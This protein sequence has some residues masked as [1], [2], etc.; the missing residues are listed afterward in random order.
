MTTDL[1]H[2]KS[3]IDQGKIVDA[4]SILTPL[5]YS[6]PHDIPAWFLYVETLDSTVKRLRVLEICL[7][8]NRG[9]PEV[10]EAVDV[11]HKRLNKLS[12]AKFVKAV[13]AVDGWKVPFFDLDAIE[14]SK[15][16]LPDIHLPV[17]E[18]VLSHLKNSSPHREA[19][20]HFD[21]ALLNNTQ[22]P[23]I[24]D[25][26][27]YFL[28]QAEKLPQ[29]CEYIIYGCPAVVHPES[30]IIFGFQKGPEIFYR[31]P[32][33]TVE[34]I[35]KHYEVVFDEAAGIKPGS[36]D[37]NSEFRTFDKYWINHGS[38]LTPSLIQKCYDFNG[39]VH[40]KSI[41][42]NIKEDLQ[43]L[44]PTRSEKLMNRLLNLSI[45]VLAIV[46]VAILYYIYKLIR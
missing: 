40:N 41:D 44:F 10:T 25:S 7:R 18:D 3:L 36:S 33:A 38:Y 24:S 20:V 32:P 1:E 8:Q 12:H 26:I 4:Q 31:L 11:L 13:T 2:A 17:N 15:G 5:I 34:T 29:P 35:S 42:L 16:R 21:H 43:K 6:N 9:D 46:A 30:G 27:Q 39:S 23:A 37:V 19:I 14:R 22:E 28:L 45:F